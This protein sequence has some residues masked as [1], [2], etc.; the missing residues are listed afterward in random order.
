MYKYKVWVSFFLAFFD[1]WLDRMQSLCQGVQIFKQNTKQNKITEKK[2][3][4]SAVFCLNEECPKLLSSLGVDHLRRKTIPLWNSSLENEFFRASLYV[5]YLQYWALCDALVSRGQV[6]VFFNGD[7]TRIYLMKEKQGG[8]IPTGL[9]RWPLKLVKHLA[10]TTC[11]SQ[12]PAGPA[13]C[14]LLNFLYLVNL[15]FRVRA[16]N[17]CCIL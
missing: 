14:C 4:L 6:L 9:K 16:P 11:V 15:K 2:K 3:N 17:G 13:G 12:S 1:Y 10:D 8:S 7:S 5:R